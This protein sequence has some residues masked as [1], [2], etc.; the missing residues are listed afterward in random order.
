V[1][2]AAA[3]VMSIICALDRVRRWRLAEAV[4]LCTFGAVW[5]VRLLDSVPQKPDDHEYDHATRGEGSG[6]GLDETMLERLV[7]LRE[8]VD[9]LA[10]GAVTVVKFCL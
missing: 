9:R 2:V 8:F 10:Q 1:S 3:S 5:D 4:F 7:R 6:F